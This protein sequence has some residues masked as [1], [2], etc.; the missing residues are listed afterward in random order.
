MGFEILRKRQAGSAGQAISAIGGALGTSTGAG[1]TASEPSL[2][3]ST[4]RV[5]QRSVLK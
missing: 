5:L 4:E 2:P 1:T 3:L